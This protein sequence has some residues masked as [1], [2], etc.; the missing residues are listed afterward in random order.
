VDGLTIAS[1]VLVAGEA[2]NRRL[3]AASIE[4]DASSSAPSA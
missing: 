3:H 1:E 4:A 2:T